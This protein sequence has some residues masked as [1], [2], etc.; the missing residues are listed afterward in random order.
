MF[1]FVFKQEN[2]KLLEE[3]AAKQGKTVDPQLLTKNIPPVQ[4]RLA[5]VV[6]GSGEAL[7]VSVRL[8]VSSRP[9]LLPKNPGHKLMRWRFWAIFCHKRSRN[10]SIR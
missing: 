9:E 6:G 3:E 8:S 7:A 2:N 10:T 1:R 5:D 4:F